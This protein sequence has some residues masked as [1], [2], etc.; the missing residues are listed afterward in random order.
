MKLSHEVELKVIDELG[1]LYGSVKA[2]IER[3][4]RERYT[5]SDELAIQRQRD[6]KPDEY[7]EY[8]A[9][10]EDC[11]ARAK[12]IWSKQE[13]VINKYRNE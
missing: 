3:L 11:K 4:I 6:T 5:V 8:D 7:A 2:I 12:E 10:V 9:F 13:E 1:V